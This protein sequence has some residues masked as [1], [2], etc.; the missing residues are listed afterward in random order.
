MRTF[1]A[2][3]VY[4][5]YLNNYLTYECLAEAYQITL[6]Q[7]EILINAGRIVNHGGIL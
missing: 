3:A 2:E 4:L 7:A 5:D 6:S 1:N